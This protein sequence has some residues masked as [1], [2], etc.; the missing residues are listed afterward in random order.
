MPRDEDRA[1]GVIDHLR[2]NRAEQHRLDQ[3]LT[4]AAHDDELG[5]DALRLIDDRGGRLARQELGL[6]LA[7]GPLQRRLHVRELRVSLVPQSLVHRPVSITEDI[8]RL[9]L[10]LVHPYHLDEAAGRPVK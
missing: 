7:T 6:D 2:R 9:R 1:G 4:A 8:G 3:S 10:A 5:A